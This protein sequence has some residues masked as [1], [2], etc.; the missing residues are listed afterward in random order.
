MM[1]HHLNT[2]P[3][4]Y[5]FPV[6]YESFPILH[7]TGLL[8]RAVSE[9]VTITQAPAPMVYS[10]ALAALSVAI[11][12]LVDVKSPTGQSGPVSLSILA[13]VESGG[14]KSLVGKFFTGGI[15][16]FLKESLEVY[17]DSLSKYK[18]QLEL[19]K[20]E[21]ALIKASMELGNK[22]QCNQVLGKLIT[23]ESS[24]P[25][26]PKLPVLLCEDIT[27]EALLCNLSEHTPNAFLFTSEGGVIFKGKGLSNTPVINSV[28]SGD[29]I[30]V[31]RKTVDSFQVK[32]A[33][34]SM[35]IQTQESAF[36]EFMGKSTNDIVGN[37][38][39]ARLLVCSP[40][41][42]CGTRFATGIEQTTDNMDAFTNKIFELLT[43]SAK[44]EDYTAKETLCFSGEA[45]AIWLDVR[46]DIEMKMGADGMYHG[47]KG[48]GSKIAENISRVAALLHC[49][50]YSNKGD[51]SKATLLDAVNLVSYFSSQYMKV[52][53]APPKYVVDAENLKCWFG[54]YVNSGRRYLKKNDILKFGPSGTR[55]KASLDTALGYLKSNW[56]IGEFLFGRTM[57]VDLLPTLLIDEA[58]V[59]QELTIKFVF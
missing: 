14:G 2:A 25:I 1:N 59:R 33:R 30:F 45:K 10:A 57:V 7:G 27:I 8:T 39:A 11:Q 58:V 3:F 55:K 32:G 20:N 41:S 5:T 26:K 51:I 49:F 48:H 50:E 56:R 31:N 35:F 18:L 22:K 6:A 21:E 40:P 29:D 15:K 43:E 12:G 42:N 24:K 13:I 9:V 52:F 4:K 53:C 16:A 23:H 19:H 46:N 34:L 36:K 17:R 44:L 37:G 47:V 38:F 54:G 28:W